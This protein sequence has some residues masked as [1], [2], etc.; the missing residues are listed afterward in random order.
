MQENGHDHKNHHHKNS[1][2]LHLLS[3]Y[4]LLGLGLSAFHILSLPTAEK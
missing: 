3:A 2:T 4:K 1:N